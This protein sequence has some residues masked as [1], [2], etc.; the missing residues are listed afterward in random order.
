MENIIQEVAEGSCGV[1]PERFIHKEE[2]FAKWCMMSLC[3]R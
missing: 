2:W 3:L 1:D